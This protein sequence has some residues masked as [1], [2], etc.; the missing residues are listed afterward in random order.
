MYASL[1]KKPNH[2][3]L[4]PRKVQW[5]SRGIL[6]TIVSEKL[7]PRTPWLSSSETLESGLSVK[8]DS[9][10]LPTHFTRASQTFHTSHLLESRFKCKCLH[11]VL[12]KFF[13]GPF[14]SDHTTLF[15]ISLC[16]R[17][18]LLRNISLLKTCSAAPA[19]WPASAF[20]LVPLDLLWSDVKEG[21]SSSHTLP[22]ECTR[23]CNS[24]CSHQRK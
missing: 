23:S 16:L 11:H 6:F 22:L 5:R 9:V 12:R 3:C 1:K 17:T 8:R 15:R 18:H 7:L 24:Y 20:C 4:K 21:V 14:V 2:G 19:E 13:Y 10:L